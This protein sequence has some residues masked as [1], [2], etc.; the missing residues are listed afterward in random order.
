MSK[1]TDQ[2]LVLLATFCGC[3]ETHRARNSFARVDIRKAI[4]T[5]FN[6]AGYA[7]ENWPLYSNFEWVKARRE[8]FAR[9]L[10]SLVDQGCNTVAICCMCERIVAD[11]IHI[12][13]H[14]RERMAMLQ[15]IA[16]ASRVVHDFADREGVNYP[17]YEMADELLDELY[18]IVELREFAKAA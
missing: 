2:T 5:G 8:Q 14:N 10:E 3:M 13:G 18:R 17:A 6:A 12:H 16:D 9:Y 11:L 7:I 15:P 1:E 4:D